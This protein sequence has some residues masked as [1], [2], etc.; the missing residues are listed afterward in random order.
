[1]GEQYKDTMFVGDVR[2]GNIYNFKL[3]AERNE[4]VL[5]EDLADKTAN[6]YDELESVI[7]GE[8][9]GLITDIQQ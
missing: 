4:L 7:F 1:M 5:A 2:T 8:G 3:N 6:D 9:F